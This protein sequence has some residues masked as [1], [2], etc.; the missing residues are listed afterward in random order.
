MHTSQA[1]TIGTVAKNARSAYD[2]LVR[3]ADAQTEVERSS[4][5]VAPNFLSGT[6]GGITMD[7]YRRIRGLAGIDVAAPV[8]NIGYLMASHTVSVDV[9]RFLDGK[10]FRQIVRITPTL[11]AGLETYRT[12]DQYVYLTR[13]PITS[14]T[15][16]EVFESETLE[17]GQADKSTRRYMMNSKYNVCFYFNGDKTGQTQWNL[18]LPMKESMIGE[19]LSDRSA[20]D[21]DLHSRMNSSQGRARPP[22]TF[23]SP[24]RYCCPPSTRQRRSAWWACA[25]P[26]RRAA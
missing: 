22:S 4:G 1:S 15:S 21:P 8:A 16:D 3:P 17:K 2:V 18:D 19:D 26:S 25:A 5:L 23:P 24:T 10:A 9:S 12:A 13:S 14:G 20:F 6:F 11:A 7:Q